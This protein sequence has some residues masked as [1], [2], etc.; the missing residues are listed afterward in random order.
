MKHT[1]TG[2]RAHL[3]QVLDHVAAT[4]EAVHVM[5]GDVELCI[6]RKKKAPA[7]KKKPRTLPRLIVGN[8]DALVHVEWPT[9]DGQ[10]P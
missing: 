10:D 1:A 6:V 9:G 8:P 3:Y 5:R 4:G 7:R 2:L